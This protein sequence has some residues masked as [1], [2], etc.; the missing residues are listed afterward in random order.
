MRIGFFDTFSGIA[1]DMALG[2]MLDLGLPLEVLQEV[3]AKLALDEVELRVSG[4]TKNGI[5]AT[6]LDV[7][8]A[9]EPERPGAAHGDGKGH[10]HSH[11]HH[12]A[13]HH[14]FRDIRKRIDDAGLGA[15]TTRR[16]QAIFRALAVAEGRVHGKDPEEVRFHEVG[17]ADALV[18]IVGTAAGLVHL[19]ID[20]IHTSPLP[21][22]DGFVHTAHGRMPVPAPATLELLRGFPTRPLDGGREL[23]TPT[24]AAILAALA[25]PAPAPPLRPLE[26]GYGAGTLDL[27]D[28]PNLLRLVVAEEADTRRPAGLPPRNPAIGH[29]ERVVLE[30]N[31][32]DMNPEFF[33]AAIEALLDA[34]ALDV[35]LTAVT[36]K[37]GRPGSCLQ[38]IAC[39]EDEE[40]LTDLI[41]SRTT[42]IG[43][44]RWP[45]LRRTLARSQRSVDTPFGTIACKAVI[46]PD[47]SERI[48]PEASDVLRA[49]REHGVPPEQIR[50][51]VE[52]AIQPSS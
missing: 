28:R 4:T 48:A 51:A 14:A 26:I 15:E 33:E 42:S 2:A 16:A 31:I 20:R 8:V 44:R 21:L 36:M 47:G 37:R 38:V 29:D 24:G 41:L 12:G 5:R 30:T 9:G 34:G 49:A 46:L 40:R 10:G 50:S 45:V 19:G 18:D 11:H 17:A 1:G 39:E 22:G 27:D 3:V 52:R 6:K 7:L 13:A 43:V 32:D 23:V 25:D 35:T